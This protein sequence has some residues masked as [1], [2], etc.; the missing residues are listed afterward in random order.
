MYEVYIYLPSLDDYR[1]Y[2]LLAAAE[3]GD[4]IL[5]KKLLSSQLLTFQ[6][7]QSLDT[8]LVRDRA[9]EY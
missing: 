4:I 1:G 9:L 3:D 8:L 7:Q 2:Q 5:F 6:H